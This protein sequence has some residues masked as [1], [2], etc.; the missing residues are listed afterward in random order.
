MDITNIDAEGQAEAINKL[1]RNLKEV[2]EVSS[3]IS[4]AINRAEA[5]VQDIKTN[6]RQLTKR[7]LPE[8]QR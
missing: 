2:D 7:E 8:S 5:E 4:N 6:K 3:K 1:M